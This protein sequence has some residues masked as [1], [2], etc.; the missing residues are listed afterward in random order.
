MIIK[1]VRMLAVVA[2]V[3]SC[4]GR[5]AAQ[6]FSD[7]FNTAASE[8]AWKINAAPTA[9]ADKQQAQFAFDYSAFGIPP[10]PGSSDTLGLRLRANLPIV[11][12]NE[13]TTR[14]AGVV[15]GLSLSPLNKDFGA[16]FQLSFYTWAN[17]F[18]APNPSG[19][20]D[21]LNSEGGTANVTFAVG[22]SG[23]VPIVVGQPG[24][25][26]NGA[27]DAV[28]FSASNDGAVAADYRVYPASGTPST[29]ASGVYA[30]GTVNDA[31]GNTPQSNLHEFYVNLFPTQAAPP[32]QLDLSFAEFPDAFN[33]QSG[34]TPP[35]SFGFAWHKVVITKNNNV[36][37]WNVNDTTVATIDASA[38]TLGGNNIAIGTSD[39][40]GTTARHPSLTFTIFDNLEVTS[41][42]GP[43]PGDFNGDTRV[44]DADYGVWKGQFGSTLDGEDFLTWQANYGTGV[45]GASSVPEPGT[46]ALA[47]VALGAAAAM[48]RGATDRRRRAL[49]GR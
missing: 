10:A 46:T 49:A 35:G 4:T 17:F 8:A 16:N 9:N 12:G 15:S 22:T 32:V 11:G 47:V 23:N 48:A 7:N 43:V 40:N 24:L 33:T 39:V 14:P 13:V 30:A 26:T 28:G 6:L 18:G 25:V 42:G 5:A 44:D 2:V 31:G 3:G 45:P 41:L 20:A 1:L 29:V 37:T 36:V 34:T 38:L 19:L 21:A 27:M